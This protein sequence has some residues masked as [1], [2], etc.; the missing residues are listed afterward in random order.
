MQAAGALRTW[1]HQQRRQLPCHSSN[2]GQQQQWRKLLWPGPFIA[3]AT[4]PVLLL[5][6][7]CHRC[8]AVSCAWTLTSSTWRPAGAASMSH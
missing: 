2:T 1:C 8:M 5:F 4:L 7:L 6:F 3:L